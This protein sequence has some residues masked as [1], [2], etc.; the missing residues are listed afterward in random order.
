MTLQDT[1]AIVTG[2][3]SGLGL[4]TAKRLA[5]A[6]AGVV[7]VDLN[8]DQGNA[9]ADEIGGVFVQADVAD[10]AQVQEAVNAAIG[11][12]PVRWVLNGA[13]IG[14]AERTVNRDGSPASLETFERVIRINLIGTFNVTRLAAAAIAT[15]EPDADGWR[16]SIINTAS[17]AAFDGQIGQAS[18]SASKGA[19]VGMTLPIARDLSSVGIRV[20]TIAPGLFDTP[21]YGTGDQAEAFKAHLGQNVPFPKRLGVADEFASMA[22]EIFT[23]AYMNGETVRLDGA[24]RMPP[25]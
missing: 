16:G 6:G 8:A 14:A 7:I 2:G 18:Y 21:I 1:S 19:I 10:T 22:M 5:A 25:K 9:A 24:I 20:N 3:A 12:A 13:G 23:N 17:A 11:I 4:A 15:T